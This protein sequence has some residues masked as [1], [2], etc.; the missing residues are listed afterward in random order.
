MKDFKTL[1][2]R[3]KWETV[4]AAVLT[5]VVGILCVALPDRM[6]NVLTVVVGWALI[7]LG[8]ATGVS[9]FLRGRIFIGSA[10]IRALIMVMV[11]MLCLVEGEVFKSVIT[12][13]FGL[14]IVFDSMNAAL[15]S[16]ALVRAR[17]KGAAVIFVIAVV[18]ACLGVVVAF[19]DFE[20]VMIFA[21]ITL[22]IEGLERLL[23]TLLVGS[24]AK[25]ARARFYPDDDYDGTQKGRD[26]LS[27]DEVEIK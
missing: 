21:G 23:F 6:G 4:L 24:K 25:R 17:V 7:V 10:L 11:G 9:I 26:V 19:S 13:L 12:I 15:D 1:F 18:T 3:L 27:E 22:M 2:K 5:I 8:V 14:Y 20:S 16:V